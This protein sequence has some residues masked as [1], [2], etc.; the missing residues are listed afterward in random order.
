MLLPALNKARDK[1]KQISCANNLKQ[2]GNAN[3]M[4]TGDYDDYYPLQKMA[5]GSKTTYFM[6]LL[7]TYLGGKPTTGDMT[8]TTLGKGNIYS[9]AAARRL[10]AKIWGCP[11][12]F[13]STNVFTEYTNS[14]GMNGANYTSGQGKGFFNYDTNGVCQGR[15]MSEIYGNPI[16]LA[17]H[18]TYASSAF[19]QFVGIG[20]MPYNA[21]RFWNAC[22]TTVAGRP[23]SF[24]L[25]HP[26]RTSNYLFVDGHVDN[27]KWQEATDSVPPT[28]RSADW[29]PKWK[30]K[31]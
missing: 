5:Y 27:M 7:A 4:Y 16:F 19:W 31:K 9:E 30:I 23:F 11:K 12:D 21:Q 28:T 17:E 3:V 22:S 26:G 8:D 18:A 2:I 14:Y 15:K 13:Y 24:G 29:S 6:H 20:A 10:N 1:A 25:Y